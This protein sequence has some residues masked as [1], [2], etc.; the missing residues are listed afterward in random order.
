[1]KI[2]HV[3]ALVSPNG[4]YGG[5]TRVCIDQSRELVRRGHDVTVFA[6][7]RNT[8]TD[9]EARIDGVPARLYPASMLIPSLGFATLRAKDISKAVVSAAQTA[10]VVHIHLGRD[11]LT[12]GV[13][14][15][16]RRARIPFVLQTHG[17]I[18][19]TSRLSARVVDRLLTGPAIRQASSVFTLTRDEDVE[20]TRLGRVS[21]PSR[22]LRN[23]IFVDE[24]PRSYQKAEYDGLFLAR[25]HPRKGLL[26][27]VRACIELAQR[28]GDLVFAYA[29]PDEG[30]LGEAQAL[31]SAAGLSNRVRYLGPIEPSRVR[32]VMAAAR[33]YCLP[34]ENEPFGMTLLEA[35]SVGTPVVLH[36]G[37][38]LARQIA[39]SGA[40]VVFGEHLNLR[41]AISKLQAVGRN[42]QAQRSALHLVQTEFGMGDVVDELERSYAVALSVANR[43]RSSK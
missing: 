9:R 25:L 30:S 26:E 15:A 35:M 33:V 17:M 18:D 39:E 32:E 4:E 11:L 28:N 21:D 36:E 37:S 12:L 42:G 1:M 13:A 38:R 3:V 6:G 43:P 34:A 29:G 16:V 31:V 5:P 27:Y 2:V 41:E 23:G 10:D 24:S 19:A 7:S 40:G 8:T 20:M 22:Y 14:R